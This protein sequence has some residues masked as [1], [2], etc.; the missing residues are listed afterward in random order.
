M[1]TADF[2]MIIILVSVVSKQQRDVSVE[3][4]PNIFDGKLKINETITK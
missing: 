1:V 3:L 2:P 4:L